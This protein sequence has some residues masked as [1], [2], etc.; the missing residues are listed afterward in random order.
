MPWT[1]TPQS[2]PS[3][4]EEQ[5]YNVTRP[6]S[7]N[8]PSNFAMTPHTPFPSLFAPLP[9]LKNGHSSPDSSI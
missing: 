9:C 3:L 5:D 8:T 4:T 6:L 2:P 7:L 1:P